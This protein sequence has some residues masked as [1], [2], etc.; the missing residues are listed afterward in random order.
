MTL[1]QMLW[2]R[3]QQFWDADANFYQRNLASDCVMLLP[4]PDG[5]LVKHDIVEAIARS[6]RWLTVEITQRRAAEL[7]DGAM[8]LVYRA[9]A[10]REGE[11][12]SYTALVSSCYVNRGGRWMLLMHQQTPVGSASVP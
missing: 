10:Q 9:K 2:A 4:T 8:A 12:A 6:S 11:S 3:E 7:G 5:I 1:E